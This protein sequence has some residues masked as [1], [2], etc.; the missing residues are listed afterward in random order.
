MLLPQ[1]IGFAYILEINDRIVGLPVSKLSVSMHEGGFYKCVDPGLLQKKDIGFPGKPNVE[2]I[3]A[4]N[5]DLL[6]EPSFHLKVGPALDKLKCGRFRVFGTFA[7]VEE[8]LA[9]VAEFGKTVGRVERAKKYTDY[10]N[11]KLDMVKERLGDVRNKKSI[12]V[13]HIINNGEKM[14]TH[15][16]KSSFAKDILKKLGTDPFGY[17][18]VKAPEYVLSKEDLLKFDPDFIFLEEINH[19]SAKYTID[20]NNGFWKQLRAFKNNAIYRVPVD[21]ESCFL[22]GW[23]FNLAAPLGIL[24]TAK[25]L[26]PEKFKDVDLD[27]EAREFYKEF[28]KIDVDK[29]R[30]AN[31][32]IVPAE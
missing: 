29:M 11:R 24:W 18:D 23:Y 25:T 6:I 31:K 4:L 5:P 20:T 28:F 10:F 26:Y 22:T 15:G 21:D 2:T 19:A 8:W 7:N 32:N 3:I 9:A 12:K 16:R 13:A 30:Q 1:A 14:I 17:G 27:R